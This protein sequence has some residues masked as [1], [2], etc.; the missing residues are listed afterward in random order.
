MKTSSRSRRRRA[1]SAAKVAANRANAR[2]S[3]GPRTDAG[4]SASRM[5]ALSHGLCSQSP[6]LPGDDLAERAQIQ[7]KYEQY[8]G[9]FSPVEQALAAQAVTLELRLQRLARTEQAL[10]EMELQDRRSARNSRRDR[11]KFLSPN[12]EPLPDHD[13]LPLPEPVE[14]VYAR[15]FR[16]QAKSPEKSG[17]MTV[18]CTWAE[19]GRAELHRVSRELVR[20]HEQRRKA[21]LPEPAPVPPSPALVAT[22]D[23]THRPYGIYSE[24]EAAQARTIDAAQD[25][26]FDQHLKNLREQVAADAA[27]QVRAQPDLASKVAMA[28]K[29]E[30]ISDLTGMTIPATMVGKAAGIPESAFAMPVATPSKTTESRAAV[31]A[32]RIAEGRAECARLDAQTKARWEELNREEEIRQ[33]SPEAI[34]EREMLLAGLTSRADR[35]ADVPPAGAVH[36]GPARPAGAVHGGPARPAATAPPVA[37]TAANRTVAATPAAPIGVTAA[38]EVAAPVAP[39]PSTATAQ[40]ARNIPPKIAPAAPTAAPVTPGAARTSPAAAPLQQNPRNEPK[41][42]PHPAPPRPHLGPPRPPR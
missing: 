30:A 4:K 9:G 19:R 34:A 29:I 10:A 26:V 17:P 20:W 3:T 42:A 22:A 40:P 15:E 33:K 27:A 16:E 7:L 5:N 38:A 31:L 12:V 41:L 36:G 13:E 28:R 1:V 25:L 21:G 18:L 11:E 39:A 2:R 14:N 24:A 6:L 37:P 32:R 35:A 8:Y 23:A